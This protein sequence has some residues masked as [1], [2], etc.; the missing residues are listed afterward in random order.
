MIMMLNLLALCIVFLIGYGKYQLSFK[1]LCPRER[2]LKSQGRRKMELMKHM[3][4]IIKSIMIIWSFRM[5]INKL[6]RIKD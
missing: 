4:S 6:T 1:W 3:E 2:E 5:I